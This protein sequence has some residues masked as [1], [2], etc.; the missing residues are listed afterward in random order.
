MQ[1]LTAL[2]GDTPGW[3][4][5]AA[6]NRT[7][8]LAGP[9]KETH[10]A[11][12]AEQAATI[13]PEQVSTWLDSLDGHY[14]MVLIDS[15]WSIAAVDPSRTIPL[16][17]TER[18]DGVLVA[19]TGADLARRAG[20]GPDHILLEQARVFALS[21][22]TTGSATLY[23]EVYG[24]LPGQFLFC[25]ADTRPAVR[26][27]HKWRPCQPENVAPEDLYAPLSTLHERIISDLVASANGRPILV[28]LSAGLDSRFIASGLVEAGYKNVQ[29]FTYGLSG[30]REALMSK[31]IAE[32]LG[33]PWT[34][35]PYT[36]RSVRSVNKSPDYL[37]YEHYADSFTAIPYPQDYPALT[38]LRARG[39]LDPDTIVVN[40]NT[41][42]FIT[43]NHILPLLA[44]PQNDGLDARMSRII[45]A[46]VTKH[47]KQWE[48][49]KTPDRLAEVERLL[50]A[51]IEGFGG[52]PVDPSGDHG[53]YEMSE[54]INRQ[55]KYVI[56]GQRC[57]E[58][59]GL[60]WRLP[61][62]NRA[63]LDFWE[64]APL[65]AKFQQRLYREVLERDNWGGAWR[66]IPV[67]P[68]RIR[69]GWLVPLRFLAKLVHAPLGR[70]R[71]HRFEKQYL[72]YWMSS[73]CSYAPWSYY[74]VAFDKRGHTTPIAWY[75]S[76][77]LK[78]AGCAWEGN[79]IK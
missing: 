16:I 49:L 37:A 71:W 40:G 43:G 12:L 41:G 21:G 4:Q 66:D 38:A 14:A 31:K 23:R 34:F 26:N 65:A 69:P 2:L 8:L 46:L 61:L 73:L 58:W 56:N 9:L 33:L 11:Q 59:L 15:D 29:C 28:P 51:E 24:L 57:Y 35:V 32:R 75:T 19:Q 76:E 25:S 47:Y 42:D 6:G 39:D 74:D 13:S 60:S 5:C 53:I 70:A 72:E 17:Y 27:Y 7:L 18:A 68:T 20:L 45:A 79:A 54:F 48:I 1:V 52:L 78:R 55:S 67:N 50:M 77:Y 64:K 62:W 22:Y 63:L 36:I 30:N 44:A 3:S 10:S